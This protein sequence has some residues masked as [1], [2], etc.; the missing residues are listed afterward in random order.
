MNIEFGLTDGSF[1]TQFAPLAALSAHYQQNQVLAPFENVALQMKTRDFSPVCKLKQV[2]V[3]I[4][5]GCETLTAF[6]SEVDGETDLA[7][8]WGWERFADQSTLSR[9]LDALTLMNI[10]QLRTATTAIWRSMSQTRQHDWRGFLLLDFDLS[11]LPCSPR[12]EASQKGYFSGKKTS[13][14]AS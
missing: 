9:T 4:L 10:E 11:G 12:A 13:P 14:D 1:N 5:A 3:S 8:I 2:L 6:N 7:A